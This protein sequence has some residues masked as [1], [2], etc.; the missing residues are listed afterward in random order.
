MPVFSFRPMPFKKWDHVVVV[1]HGSQRHKGLSRS[2]I[3]K[4]I[5][6]TLNFL[7]KPRHVSIFFTKLLS[8]C[9]PFISED[10]LQV[11]L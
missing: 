6:Q 4:R 9:R 10:M 8:S 3:K 7:C 1:V 5:M 2:S 11:D